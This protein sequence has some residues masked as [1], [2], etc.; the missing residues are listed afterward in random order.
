M[1]DHYLLSVAIVMT[2]SSYINTRFTEKTTYYTSVSLFIL[3]TI[4]GTSSLDF[5]ILLIGRVFQGVSASL[6][7]PLM[8]NI[9]FSR[10]PTEKLGLWM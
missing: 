10:I 5:T 2:L 6:A 1:G 8:F 3:G 9:I 7:M 4:I